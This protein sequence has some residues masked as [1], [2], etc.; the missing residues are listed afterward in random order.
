MKEDEKIKEMESWLIGCVDKLCDCNNFLLD[1][2]SHKV[3]CTYRAAANCQ[4]DGWIELLQ[5]E[6]TSD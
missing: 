3:G 2:T 4:P 5:E 6:L 1:P